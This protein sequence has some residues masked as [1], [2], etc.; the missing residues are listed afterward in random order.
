VIV[1]GGGGAGFGSCGGGGGGGRL[2]VSST[3]INVVSGTALSLSVGAGGAGGWLG[4]YP[5]WSPG[6]SGSA[7]SLTIAGTTYSSSGGGGGGGWLSSVTYAGSTGGSGGGGTSCPTTTGGVADTS[8]VSGFTA[9][10]NAGST[11]GPNTYEGGGGGGAGTA[12]SIRNG[13]DGR[14]VWGVTLAGGG[15]GWTNGLG[16]S[17]GGGSAGSGDNTLAGAG[18]PGTDGLGGG[19]GGGNRGGSGRV[20]I[21]YLVSSAPA[22]TAL[23]I[24]S[25]TNR[26]GSTLTATAGTWSGSPSYTYQWQNAPSADGTFSNIAYATS[27]TYKLKGE[28]LAK[29]VRVNVTATVAGGSTTVSSSPTTEILTTTSGAGTPCHLGGTCIVGDVGPGTGVVF[30]VSDAGFTCGPTLASTCNY[31]EV[32]RDYWNNLVDDYASATGNYFWDQRNPKGLIG[33]NAQG[34]AIGSGYK[35]TRAAI[36]FPLDTSSRAVHVSDSYS[37]SAF[38]VTVDDW[39]LPAKDEL[40]AVYTVRSN[41]LLSFPPGG[42][43]SSTETDASQVGEVNF[44][45]GAWNANAATWNYAGVRPIRAFARTITVPAIPTLNT[46]TG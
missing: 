27:S 15:G 46:A 13:G 26:V 5:S 19:G 8:T 28:S 20:M 30:Y 36:A 16:G 3:P 10:G 34:T 23:P 7:S 2:L 4:L 38:G 44:A 22:N 11:G 35:N 31:L 12:G 41:S 40:L 1:G 37:L 24:I 14:T 42:Y 25:G 17:G 18:N 33:A 6:T 21:R 29:Y 9:Y 32:A 39:Y 45:N 43:W